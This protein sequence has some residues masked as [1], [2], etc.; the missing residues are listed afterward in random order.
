VWLSGEIRRH[1]EGDRE[2]LGATKSD[3]E[4]LRTKIRDLRDDVNAALDVAETR[5]DS[6][7]PDGTEIQ[8]RLEEMR[9]RERGCCAQSSGRAGSAERLGGRRGALRE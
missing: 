1:R 2:G 3:V 8:V 4:S 6:D 5:G 7:V 9:E